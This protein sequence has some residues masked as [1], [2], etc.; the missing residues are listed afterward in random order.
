VTDEVVG[1][2]GAPPTE[3]AA[4]PPPRFPSLPQVAASEAPP[5]S[6][7]YM[8][9]YAREDTPAAQQAAA[10]AGPRPSDSSGAATA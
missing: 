9:L 10:A 2:G 3:R 4:A 1:A 5:R 8:Y 7:G 6:L